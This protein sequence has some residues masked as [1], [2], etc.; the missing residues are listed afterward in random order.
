MMCG[1]GGTVSTKARHNADATCTLEVAAAVIRDVPNKVYTVCSN[2]QQ[3]AALCARTSTRTI[4][5][6]QAV[7]TGQL[8]LSWACFAGMAGGR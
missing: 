2:G 3:N 5:A 8:V 6:A 1:S 4:C 7:S